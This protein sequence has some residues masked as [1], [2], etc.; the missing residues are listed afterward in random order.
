M[1]MEKK[2]RCFLCRRHL[3]N[4]PQ[5]ESDLSHYNCP[6]CGKYAIEY[7]EQVATYIESDRTKIASI[8]LEKKLSGTPIEYV[9]TES[10][11]DHN[12]IK[13]HSIAELIALFPRT[14][15]EMLDKALLN[16]SLR[17]CDEITM[18]T[19]AWHILYC[20]CDNRSNNTTKVSDI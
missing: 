14:P 11:I 4:S 1:I 16:I 6:N 12:G 9:S 20:I 18:A 10:K 2:D 5:H 8:M 17:A 15:I 19:K 7:Q 13:W 3:V